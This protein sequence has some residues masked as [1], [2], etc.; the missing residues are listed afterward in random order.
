MKLIFSLYNYNEIYK[1]INLEAEDCIKKCI[2]SKVLNQAHQYQCKMT[3][4]YDEKIQ[5]SKD[6]LVSYLFNWIISSKL[7]K[8]LYLSPLFFQ[9]P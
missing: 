7:R 3:N 8:T 6:V 9:N 4:L 2:K 5:S 1:N